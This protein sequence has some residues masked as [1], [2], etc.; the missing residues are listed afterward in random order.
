MYRKYFLGLIALCLSCQSIDKRPTPSRLLTEDEM[1]NTL[2]ELTILKA[3]STVASGIK[4]HSGIDFKDYIN[5]KIG[6]DSL[7]IAENLAY[8]GYEPKDLKAIYQRVEDSLEVRFQ[9]H[10]SLYNRHNKSNQ[11]PKTFENLKSD[12][13]FENR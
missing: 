4:K 8:Y 7:T 9:L 11:N 10:D 2:T 3:T 5:K 12:E 1:V 13:S 6:I